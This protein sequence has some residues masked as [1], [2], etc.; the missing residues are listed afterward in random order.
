MRAEDLLELIDEYNSNK[1]EMF[2]KCA[3]IFISQALQI[4]PLYEA[5][6]K[7]GFE[8]YVDK[9]NY[10]LIIALDIN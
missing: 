3:D 5:L 2:D 4:Q 8:C 1:E 9:E 7:K 6:R 10:Q